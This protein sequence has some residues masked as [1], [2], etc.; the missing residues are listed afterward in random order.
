MADLAIAQRLAESWSSPADASSPWLSP[1]TALQAIRSVAVPDVGVSG[2]EHRPVFP[3][4]TSV[5]ARGD[6]RPERA[7]QS[8][9]GQ[10]LISNGDFS[11]G[12]SMWSVR[13]WQG[14]GDS[15]VAPYYS[16]QAGALCTT[17]ER[18][19]QVLGG[20]PWD[21]RRLTPSSFELERGKRYRLSLRAWSSGPKPVDLVVKVGHQKAPYTPALVAA[22]PVQAEPGRFDIEFVAE[23]DDRMA[24]LAFV[25]SSASDGPQGDTAQGDTAQGDTAPSELCIDDVMLQAMG[26]ARPRPVGAKGRRPHTDE[27]RLP[28]ATSRGAPSQRR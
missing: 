28:V 26:A 27:Q 16:V 15:S 2:L 24:G 8:V 12:D 17:L 25:A 11:Y 1:S 6:V 14:L 22:V 3:E 23:R 7:G 5:T 4:G 20:W 19:Q 21:D 10:N 18:G 13:N 9:A